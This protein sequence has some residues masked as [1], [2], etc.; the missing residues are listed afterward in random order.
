MNTVVRT[1]RTMQ[2]YL[3]LGNQSQVCITIPDSCGTQG[4]TVSVWVKPLDC[5]ADGGGIVT[6]QSQ[7]QSSFIIA[8]NPT[9]LRYIL[10]ELKKI[11]H[12]IL[13]FFK[14]H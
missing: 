10:F 12:F 9:E 11:T 1:D 13:Y 8:C 3:E 14:Y 6:S 4:G 7:Y 5:D 2:Q